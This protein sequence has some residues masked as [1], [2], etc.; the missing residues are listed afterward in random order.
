MWW[1]NKLPETEFRITDANVKTHTCQFLKE[2]N[3]TPSKHTTMMFYT[4][5]KHVAWKMLATQ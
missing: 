5:R 4:L 2:N 1:T 3:M